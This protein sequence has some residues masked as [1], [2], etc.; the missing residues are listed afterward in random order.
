MAKS[1]KLPIVEARYKLVNFNQVFDN[2][3]KKFVRTTR[4]ILALM[5]DEKD[6]TVTKRDMLNKQKENE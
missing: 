2:E 6:K 4:N 1:K 5:L 3:Q